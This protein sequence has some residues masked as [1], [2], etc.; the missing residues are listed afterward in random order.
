MSKLIGLFPG[1]GSQS[2]GMGQA[3]AENSDLAKDIFAIADK[4]LG[5]SIQ[6]LC[7]NGPIEDLTLTQNAQPAILTV[8]HICYAL[9]KV[10][11]VAA[12]GHSLGEF[13][14]L[15]ASGSIKFEDAVSLVHKRGCYMQEAVAAGEG[16][17]AAV[18]GTEE[19]EIAKAIEQ[20]EGI[21]E[22]ANLN[23][24]GQTVVSGASAAVAD[25]STILQD[26]GA[27][28]IPLNVS[29]PFHS[30]LMQ[31]AAERLEA[32]LAATTFSDPT[33]PVYANVNALAVTSGDEARKLLVKQVTGSVR[34]TESIL[35]MIKAEQADTFVEFGNGSVLTKLLKRI[36]KTIER[37]NVDSIESAESLK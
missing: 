24:P 26:A 19:A 12:A 6:E 10:P 13:S 28:V 20:V 23:C 21:V 34:W 17:M 4:A 22:I 31:P 36:D 18:M 3:I 1:Q 37:K 14:A 15:V 27:K 7:F 29:A 11:L 32:D 35:N 2:V 25:L 8:S 16:A 33:F 9:A 30:S 5:F